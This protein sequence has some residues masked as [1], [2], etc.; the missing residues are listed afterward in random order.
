[1]GADPRSAYSYRHPRSGEWAHA[2]HADPMVEAAASYVMPAWECLA[3]RVRQQAAGPTPQR[4][5]CALVIGFGRGFEA[6]AFARVL[7]A[8][9]PDSRWELIGL[10]PHPELLEP[11]PPRWSGFGASEAPWWGHPPSSWSLECSDQRLSVLRLG[12]EAWCRQAA[13]ECCDAFLLDLFS[14]AKHPEDWSPG[15]AA[16][17][18]RTAAPGAVLAGYSC[19]RSVREALTEA[20][21]AVEVLRRTGQRDSLRARWKSEGTP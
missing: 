6:A 1:M 7:R 20:G 15:W 12:L 18:A 8:D 2:L 19:A 21:W 10:E 17:L 9:A 3:E 16:A 13:P 5:W 11:W 4:P 14:P